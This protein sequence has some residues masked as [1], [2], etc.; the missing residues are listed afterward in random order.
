MTHPVCATPKISSSIY[1]GLILAL[2]V[3][4]A[5]LVL[6]AGSER[7]T[8]GVATSPFGWNRVIVIYALSTLILSWWMARRLTSVR[9]T[10]SQSRTKVVWCIVG[11]GISGLTV[12]TGPAAGYV[13]DEFQAGPMLRGAGRILWCVVLQVPWLMFA[14]AVMQTLER[15]PLFSTGNLLM[16]GLM[17]AI[18]V[19]VSFLAVFLDEQTHQAHRYWHEMKIV[20][21]RRIVQRLYD[22]GSTRPLGERESDGGSSAKRVV[23]PREALADLEAGA[24][25]FEENVRLRSAPRDL[26]DQEVLELGSCYVAL[27]KLDEA[28][29]ALEPVSKRDPWAALRLAELYRLMD[30]KQACQTSAEQALQLAQRLRPD[31]A[32]EIRENEN[33]QFAA[34]EMLV[35]LAGERADYALAEGLLREALERLPSRRADV[36]GR[37]AKHFEFMGDFSQAAEHQ[38][39]AASGNPEQYAPP[40]AL[41]RNVL[42][43]GAPV[44][45][46]RPKSSRYK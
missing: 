33:L 16:L 19:P 43:H 4:T 8:L 2:V 40:D 11:I 17:T 9:A 21:A 31:D 13:L 22:V 1:L 20:K 46:A 10:P 37:L 41:W 18:G 24:R 28:V 45:L 34:Y 23:T 7:Q 15:R 26:T 27:D 6:A 5:S 29:A 30:R 3:S 25:F 14:T 38:A 36:D 35:A 42:S 12:L 39:R 32:T 44:G